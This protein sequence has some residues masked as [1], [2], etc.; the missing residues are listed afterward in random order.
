MGREIICRDLGILRKSSNQFFINFIYYINNL[1]M[2]G[3]K[4]MLTF[5]RIKFGKKNKIS[6]ILF[7]RGV[8]CSF[9]SQT[10]S[11]ETVAGNY[12]PQFMK[13]CKRC[14]IY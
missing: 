12:L 14:T 13:I 3:G 2:R 8:V 5:W 6:G 11:I 10:S 1:C 4:G 9:L 7:S